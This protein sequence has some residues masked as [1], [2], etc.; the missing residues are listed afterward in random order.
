LESIKNASTSK[1]AP[2]FGK[3]GGGVQIYMDPI[4]DLK[5][6]GMIPIVRIN[7]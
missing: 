7:F 3:V 2:W 5:K 1:A 4:Y 6:S